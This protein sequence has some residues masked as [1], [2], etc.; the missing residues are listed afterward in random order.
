MIDTTTAPRRSLRFRCLGCLRE[1]LDRIDAAHRDAT[2]RTTGNWNSGEILDHC[3]ILFE[4]G[5]DG[6]N[7]TLPWYV[8][9]MGRL[10]RPLILSPK[11]PPMRPGI[12]LPADAKEILPR[13]G[14][15]FEDGMARMRRALARLE[16]GER[17]SHPS[18]WLGPLT[19]DQWVRINLSHTQ[20]HLGFMTYAGAEDG[21]PGV[22]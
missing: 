8:R 22:R 14:V 9:A 1:E 18:P 3:A 2:L 6:S 15:T 5:L 20:M 12:K 17:M 7:S 10:M 4:T 16:R 13:P 21:R 11:A 19:H